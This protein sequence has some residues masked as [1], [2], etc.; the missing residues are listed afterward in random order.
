MP[1]RHGLSAAK[2]A[3]LDQ[4]RAGRLASAPA[5][6]TTA[7]AAAKFRASLQQLELWNLQQ[8]S[9]GTASANISFAATVA[10]EL[11]HAALA[12]SLAAL[13]RRH[14]TL[15]TTFSAQDGVVWQHVHDEPLISLTTLDLSGLRPQAASARA[16]ELANE[17]ACQ[18][19]DLVKGPL[20]RVMA[21]RTRPGSHLVAAVAHHAIA[22]GWSLAIAMSETAQLYA[23]FTGG[24]AASLPP[25]PL[26]YRDYA[27]WQWQ[28][29][30]SQEALGHASYW[31]SRIRPHC[32]AQIAGD[33]DP[34]A[35][36]DMRGGLA[37]IALPE[38]L[39]AAVRQIAAAGHA[40]V[41]MVLL[42]AFAVL[43]RER[44]QDEVTSVGTPVACRNL[45]QTRPLIGC[46]ASMVPIFV[47]V[48]DDTPFDSL[49]QSVRAESAAAVTHE[50]YP[51][52]IYLNTV[53]PDRDFASHPLIA[54]Q[55][56][57]QPPMQPFLLAGA[58]LEPVALDRGETRMP[59]AVHLWDDGAA[60]Y[61]T[62]GYSARL[63]SEST[64]DA[65]IS[66]YFDIIEH[67]AADP[68]QRVG[69]L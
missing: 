14:E 50:A 24:T 53:E 23:E 59:V 51:L 26:Q 7:P 47:T 39:C 19:F 28:W 49:L 33:A 56:G 63:L 40:S 4:W 10:A 16:V 11:D 68:G 55:F 60:I 9:P 46:F 41:F 22:D 52:D 43:L 61:G 58:R 21:Y 3:L 31:E 1:D 27:H 2:Q 34:Q 69:K 42:A 45:P 35:R 62:V 12:S 67:A 15:R 64:V 5:G 30:D 54:A 66:R 29:L 20:L 38:P 18:P 48:R 6:I 44:T 17:A 36:R 37:D 25:L 32:A 8:R 57:L 13:A 65:M